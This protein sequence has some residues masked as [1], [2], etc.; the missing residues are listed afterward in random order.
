VVIPW[1]AEQTTFDRLLLAA[2]RC[3]CEGLPGAFLVR[4]SGP[5]F[6]EKAVEAAGLIQGFKGVIAGPVEEGAVR[7]H[8]GIQP[9][10][11]DA[12]W[13][14]IENWPRVLSVGGYFH[15]FASRLGNRDSRFGAE[16]VRNRRARRG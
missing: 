1:C 6:D 11:Q 5:A 3:N 10:D 12:D 4:G 9:V 15:R 2:D 7:I 16:I 13:Q 14:T 8:Q